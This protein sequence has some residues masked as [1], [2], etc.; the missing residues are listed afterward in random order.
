RVGDA[1]VVG[2]QRDTIAACGKEQPLSER[3]VAGTRQ[4]HEAERDQA[5]GGRN[6]R[7]RQCPRRQHSAEQG[8]SDHRKDHDERMHP[9][10]QLRLAVSRLNS[11]SG[12]NI[13]TAAM[14]RQ[15]MNNSAC[16]I[17]CT[18]VARASPTRTA[19]IAAASTLPSPPTTTMAKLKMMTSDV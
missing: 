4:Y 19:P 18:E 9:P 13:S 2:D 6:G 7:K 10:Y 1:P 16:G 15:I 14:I 8:H 5:V 11:P 17:R 12:R 3:H